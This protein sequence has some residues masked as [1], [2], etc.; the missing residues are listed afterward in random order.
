MSFDLTEQI[1]ALILQAIAPLQAELEAA[2]QQIASQ[3]RRIVYL[4]SCVVDEE[5]APAPA[6]APAPPVAEE[7]EPL[8]TTHEEAAAHY[9][10]HRPHF[11]RLIENQTKKVYICLNASDKLN[12]LRSARRK[13]L[14]EY[15]TKQPHLVKLLS[16]K[17]AE[18]EFVEKTGFIKRFAAAAEIP[19]NKRINLIPVESMR[20]PEVCAEITLLTSTLEKE[21]GNYGRLITIANLFTEG[22]ASKA[23]V[24]E[25]WGQD[26][27]QNKFV[28]AY[29]RKNIYDVESGVVME[30]ARVLKIREEVEKKLQTNIGKRTMPNLLSGHL[31][32]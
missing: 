29:L 25:K 28:L 9:E 30:N 6:P 31:S 27:E 13:Y 23:S 21:G 1:Q 7:E 24:D 16:E 2:K 8:V 19:T 4:E 26:E 3:E 20:R 18:R 32:I 15:A 14:A 11:I 17:D 22:K 5:P 10:Q 12:V